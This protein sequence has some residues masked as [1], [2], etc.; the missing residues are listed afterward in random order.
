MEILH[1]IQYIASTSSIKVFTTISWESVLNNY[2]IYMYSSTLFPWLDPFYFSFEHKWFS[3]VIVDR[4]SKYTVSGWKISQKDDIKLWLKKYLSDKYFL[5]ATHNIY[6]YRIITPEWT[7][8]EWKNDDWESWA[9]QCILT[10]LQRKNVANGIVVVTRYF[11]GVQLHG[12]RFRHVVDA[13]K[14]FLDKI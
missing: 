1:I 8:I 4:W 3:N 7:I 13:T 11:G 2:S 10:Q 6:A 9:W 5:K 12:D 14:I